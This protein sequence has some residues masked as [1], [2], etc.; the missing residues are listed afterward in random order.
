MLFVFFDLLKKTFK[1]LTMPASCCE[2]VA[3]PVQALNEIDVTLELT[4]LLNSDCNIMHASTQGKWPVRTG[5]G[6][7]QPALDG[8]RTCTVC[9]PFQSVCVPFQFVLGTHRGY[10][11]VVKGFQIRTEAVRKRTE[12][13]RKRC[14]Y[15]VSLELGPS[16]ARAYGPFSLW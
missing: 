4:P 11:P 9:V 13:V 6:W 5:I 2:I 16:Y 12:M 7:T 3:T 8:C 10:V 14:K 15:G 1:S